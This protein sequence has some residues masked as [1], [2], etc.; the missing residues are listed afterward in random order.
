MVNMA[1]KDL[2]FKNKKEAP[3]SSNS[4][5]RKTNVAN[6]RHQVL[7]LHVALHLDSYAHLL[8]SIK[9]THGDIYEGSETFLTFM[10][11]G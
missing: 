6:S 4:D 2:M 8:V 11:G 1:R 5:A 9:G 7:C 3:R 10:T